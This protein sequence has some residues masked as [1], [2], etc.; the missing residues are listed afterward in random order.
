M[1][2]LVYPRLLVATTERQP[3]KRV[4]ITEDGV[5]RSYGDHLERVLRLVAGLREQLGLAPEDRFAVM[6]ANSARHI[7]LWHAAL[8]GGGVINPLNLRF[9]PRELVHVLRDSGA[10]VV[11]T[12]ALF[13]PTIAAVRDEA[14]LETVVLMA[15]GTQVPDGIPADVMFETLVAGDPAR[16]WDEPEESDPCVL[17]YTGGTTGLPKGVLLEQ[18]AMTLTCYHARMHLPHEEDEV[19][20]LQTPMFHAASFGGIAIVPAFGGTTAF[21]PFFDPGAVIAAIAR[22]GATSSVMVPTMIAMV[23]DHPDFTPETFT[24]LR[25]LTYGASPMPAVLLERL[26]RDFPKLEISQ[27]YGMTESAALLTGLGTEDHVP[28]SPRLASVGRALPGIALTIQDELGRPVGPHQTGEVCVRSGNMMREYWNRPEETAAAFRGGWY[29]TGDAGYLDEEGY[30]Y[31]VDRLKDMIVTGGENVYS[32]EVE[33][34]IAEHPDVL[35]V[36]VIGVPDP[37]WGEAVHAVVVLQPG[38]EVSED[39]L[40]E[41]AR[42]FIA[43]YKI[44]KSFQFRTD[45]LPLSG[46]L[47]VL[48]RELRAPFWQDRDRGVN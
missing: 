24:T 13:A 4:L 9:S 2:E 44:P 18:R 31:L 26:L 39:E 29:H 35:Q 15:D 14:G 36:A 23:M 45:P 5:D 28:G 37:K 38:A 3:D 20:L 7:E 8:F 27:A 32:T 30:L 11:F 48:K 25:R 42:T 16:G 17:M 21:V 41:H 22:F 12:D 46:A 19:Y 6:A 47:K 33:N 1:R 40:R 43:G 34:A 10:K